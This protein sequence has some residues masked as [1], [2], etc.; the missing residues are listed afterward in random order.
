MM[1][2]SRRYALKSLLSL[3]GYISLHKSSLGNNQILT[4]KDVIV[5]GA[6]ISGLIAAS[7]LI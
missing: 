3:I 7:T 1:K 6:G 4:G 5:I 2:I